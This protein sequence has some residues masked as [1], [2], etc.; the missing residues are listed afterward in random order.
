MTTSGGGG[1]VRGPVG[2]VVLVAEDSATARAAIRHHLTSYGYSV[3]EA[4]DGE[5]ALAVV[6][7]E[8]PDA[9]L[10]DVE[11]PVLDGHAVLAAMQRDGALAHIPVVFLTGRHDAAE[12]VAGL[13]AGA[14]DY[15]HKPFEAAELVARVSAA[16]RVKRLQDELRHRYEELNVLSRLDALTG[17]YNRGHL[18]ERLRDLCSASR[19]HGFPI[20][21]LIIDLDNF[22]LVN[23]THGHPVGDQVLRGATTC[24]GVHL[25]AEDVPGRWGGEELMVLLP[26]IDSQGAATVADRILREIAAA[27]VTTPT[28]AVVYITASIGVCTA[29]GRTAEELVLRADQAMYKAKAGG[30]N[31]VVVADP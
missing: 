10:L 20:S 24:V 28:G 21:V 13:Q 30:R 4:G 22:K 19:R 1:D 3:V 2:P 12:L 14:H 7:R 8:Q 29:V 9:V 23:D 15:L 26:Y 17:L 5:E 11:M 25:R 6:R 27:S 16:V 31:Q 18:E